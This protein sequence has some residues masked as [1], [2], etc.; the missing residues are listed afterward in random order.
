MTGPS[1]VDT[2]V[3]SP[4]VKCVEDSGYEG[5]LSD[6]S[7]AYCAGNVHTSKLPLRPVCYARPFW[8][9]YGIHSF[10]F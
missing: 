7:D 6:L 1:A 5:R 3:D 10:G 2:R 4:F 9:P 8:S